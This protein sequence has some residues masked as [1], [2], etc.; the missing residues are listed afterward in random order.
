MRPLK[1]AHQCAETDEEVQN[2]AAVLATGYG[3]GFRQEAD[4]QIPR[5]QTLSA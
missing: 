2:K 5:L 1:T 3:G 4:F